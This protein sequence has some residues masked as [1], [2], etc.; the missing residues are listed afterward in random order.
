MAQFLNGPNMKWANETPRPAAVIFAIVATAILALTQLRA[1]DL[2]SKSTQPYQRMDFGPALFWTLQIERGNIAYK[3]I[4]I[5]LDAGAG[6]VSKG[7]AWMIY[8][9]DTLR[10]A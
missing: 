6:G 4:A 3:G 8:D 1:A 9:H 7:R 5:R 10:V 2:P